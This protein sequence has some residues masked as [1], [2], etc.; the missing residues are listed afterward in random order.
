MRTFPRS[1]IGLATPWGV[2]PSKSPEGPPATR[3]RKCKPCSRSNPATVS[4]PPKYTG[5]Y[6][7]ANT[8]GSLRFPGR[9][10]AAPMR[11][12][13]QP[14]ILNAE[15]SRAL[16]QPRKQSDLLLWLQGKLP[17]QAA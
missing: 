2:S 5:F 13:H 6:A 8:F 9:A 10:I 1:T 14:P 3:M 4:K 12:P 11:S 17:R 16:S 7:A 15:F